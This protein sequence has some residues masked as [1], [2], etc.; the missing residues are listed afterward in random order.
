MSEHDII[1]IVS[2]LP[3]SGTSLMMR[4]LEAG[5]VPVLTDE[6]RP[7][8]VD[9]PRGYYELERVK[10][11]ETDPSF[12][13]D[14]RGRAV[15]IISELLVHIPSRY[16]CRVLFMRR[17]MPEILASQY[18][19]LL[20]RGK[21]VDT[22]SDAEMAQLFEMHLRRVEVWLQQQPNLTTLYVD[23]NQLLVD[24]T[25]TTAEVNEFMGGHLDTAAIATVIEPTLYRQRSK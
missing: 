13:E 6:Q 21:P 16:R 25:T 1:T 12:L 15:K 3:R 14:A 17:R 9:N 10:R 18:Q 20:R 8:D 22:I 23:Y 19:M 2:G 11:I 24:P 7:A 4:M 5:G